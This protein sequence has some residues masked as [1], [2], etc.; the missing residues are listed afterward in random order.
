MTTQLPR[1]VEEIIDYYL[2][3]HYLE[4]WRKNIR[5]M[6]E[7]YGEKVELDIYFYYQEESLNWY[8]SRENN[9][10]MRIFWIRGSSRAKIEENNLIKSFKSKFTTKDPFTISRLP[11]KY[12]YSS[13]YNS[14]S[15]FK[16]SR[17][18]KNNIN[19]F[20]LYIFDLNTPIL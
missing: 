11:Q 10:K 20:I 2:Q 13:G 12:F 17:F 14:K 8:I 3:I 9:I 1:L 6:H 18:Q 4:K 15:G 19:L 5:I 7:E 16:K